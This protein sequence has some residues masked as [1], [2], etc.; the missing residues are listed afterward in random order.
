M[1]TA[2]PAMMSSLGQVPQ[3]LSQAPQAFSSLP[4]M[5]SQGA[6]Q[7]SGLLGPLSGAT[8]LGSTPAEVAPLANLGAAPGGAAALSPAL[9][10]GISAAAGPANGVMSAFT[11]PVNSFSAPNQPK[12]PG[13][14]NIAEEGPLPAPVSGSPGL[15]GGGL[16]GAPMAAHEGTAG[17]GAKAPARTLQLT[18]RGTANRGNG[19]QN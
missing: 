5:L 1:Q 8:A 17:Q 10:G 15:A 13:A 14:W 12:L 3:M 11:K 16:Y 19:P 6:G 2:L 7:F 4:Q 18:G 9:S